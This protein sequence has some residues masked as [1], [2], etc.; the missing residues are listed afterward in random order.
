MLRSFNSPRWAA[1]PLRLIV[2]Y[3]FMQHGY[4]KLAK[5][6]EAFAIILQSLGVPYALLMSWLTILTEL[7]GG[8]S[9][10][11]G[12]FIP[13]ASIPMIA[14]LLV[15]MFKV[16]LQYGFSSIKLVAITPSGA[17]FGPAG[18]ECDLLYIA[19][20]VTLVLAGSGP[21]AVDSYFAD[22]AKAVIDVERVHAD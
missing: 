1:I 20:L 16:H 15:A 13:I 3:G 7:I 10:L 6:P 8:A 5:G 21:F 12:A 17:R 18:Y 9:V 2:G 11:V 14:V 22:H 19:C 4:A